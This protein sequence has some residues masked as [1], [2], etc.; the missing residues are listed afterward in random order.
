MPNEVDVKTRR[1][2]QTNVMDVRMRRVVQTPQ[3]KRERIR[4]HSAIGMNTHHMSP[5]SPLINVPSSVGS[6]GLADV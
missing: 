1:D 6:N 3:E 4:G 2:A 5:R